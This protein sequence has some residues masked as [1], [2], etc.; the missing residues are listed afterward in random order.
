MKTSKTIQELKQHNKKLFMALNQLFGFNFEAAFDVIKTE[1][2]FTINKIL[3]ESGKEPRN[4]KTVILIEGGRYCSNDNLKIAEITGTGA[5][6][7]NLD[8]NR[9]CPIYY[10]YAG[11]DNI[12]GRGRFNEIRKSATNIY[13]ITQDKSLLLEPWKEKPVDFSNRIPEPLQKKINDRRSWNSYRKIEPLLFD[14]SGYLISEKQENLRRRAAAL[15]AERKKAAF[16]SSDNTR[17]LEDLRRLLESTKKFLCDKLAEA[18]TYTDIKKIAGSMEYYRGLA[19][20]YYDY[21]LLY[22]RDNEKSLSSQD[23][24]INAANAIKTTLSK[25]KE[26]FI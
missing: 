11:M 8:L 24:F 6:D 17:S 5:N 19:G 21:E 18:G 16:I 22:K 3:K 1:G 2:P 20:A 25:I 26:A 7:F 23:A 14:R 12:N 10:Y 15:R 13:I 4:F 9:L